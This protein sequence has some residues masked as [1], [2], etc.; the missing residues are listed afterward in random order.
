ML[1]R[2]THLDTSHLATMSASV[3]GDL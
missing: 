2:Y 1:Q 3:F